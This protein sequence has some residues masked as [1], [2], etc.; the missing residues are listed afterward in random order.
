MHVDVYGRQWLY[1]EALYSF[2]ATDRKD[3][4]W[5]SVFKPTV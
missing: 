3:L 1:K 2:I 5:R 4:L